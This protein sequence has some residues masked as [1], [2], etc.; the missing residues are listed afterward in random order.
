MIGAFVLLVKRMFMLTV[1]HGRALCS[2]VA[3]AV[4]ISA[5]NGP[6]SKHRILP[7]QASGRLAGTCAG[8]AG[9]VAAGAATGE[10]PPAT[11]ASAPPAGAALV[12]LPTVAPLN[13]NACSWPKR[14]WPG[15]ISLTSRIVRSMSQARWPMMAR[16]SQPPPE[17]ES[18]VGGL[19]GLDRELGIELPAG[20]SAMPRTLAGC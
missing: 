6:A 1:C 14:Y 7:T 15:A 17:L 12:M 9:A 13:C 4:R 16:P 20:I 10:A 11:V 2:R 8:A 19:T 3:V 5:E 18:R